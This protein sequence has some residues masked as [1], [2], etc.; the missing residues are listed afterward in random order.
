MPGGR[1]GAGRQRPDRKLPR[2]PGPTNCWRGWQLTPIRPRPAPA[3]RT[4]QSRHGRRTGFRCRSRVGLRLRAAAPG[5]GTAI[6]SADTVGEHG[7]AFCP[8]RLVS[9]DKSAGK[10]EA[11]SRTRLR[12]R[13]RPAGH[14]AL[15]H[16]DVVHAALDGAGAPVHG[17]AVGDGVEEP[18]L[19]WPRLISDDQVEQVITATLEQTPPA[20]DTH[21]STWSMARSAGMSQSE[22]SRVWRTLGHDNWAVPSG[23]VDLGESVAQVLTSAAAAALGRRTPR[24]PGLRADPAPRREKAPGRRRARRPRSPGRTA[25]RLGRRRHR[26]LR[27]AGHA[28]PRQRRPPIRERA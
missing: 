22:I 5:Q 7:A 19:D 17:Q 21:W 28:V 11:V 23:A 1:R 2:C 4:A 9:A 12:I 14:L 27:R 8:R 18:R 20:G 25:D 6:R 10:A 3:G 13:G 24:P 26:R 15:D 16:L